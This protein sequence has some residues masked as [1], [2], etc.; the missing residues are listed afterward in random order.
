MGR[1]LKNFKKSVWSIQTLFLNLI[2]PI[3]CLGCG[4]E[5]VWICEDCAKKLK[6]KE[7]Q[8]CPACGSDNGLGRVCCEHGS[9][10]Y[11]DG[12]WAAGNYED[13][14]LSL[15]I[16]KFK[17]NFIRDL[18][19]CLNNFFCFYLASFKEKILTE[20]VC[21]PVIETIEFKEVGE[22]E[23]NYLEEAIIGYSETEKRLKTFADLENT[24]IIPVPLHPRRLR[25]R[26]FNQAQVLAQAASEKFNIN[27]EFFSLKRIKY[28]PPQVSLKE[29]ER[30]INVRS[31]FS[32]EGKNLSGTNIIL[33]DD[34][35]TT[36]AT[37]NECARV[38][39]ENGAGEVWG[40]VVAK[41]KS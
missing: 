35:A 25:W 27:A 17:Y 5:E 24:I 13:S 38:L 3:E 34:I 20:S 11:L 32:W 30:K 31:C 16:K 1:K 10:F 14:L 21:E 4:R 7:R 19:P 39:K 6:P 8:T 40:A 36:G 15:L 9:E 26:G 23:K 41:G 37:L 33:I 12:I 18:A 2:F 22:T 29:Q 28:R